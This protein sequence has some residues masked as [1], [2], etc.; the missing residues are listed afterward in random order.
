VK[1]EEKMEKE[2]E[3]PKAKKQC[4]SL[5]N[6]YK[7]KRE[8]DEDVGNYKIFKRRSASGYFQFACELLANDEKTLYE[9]YKEYQSIFTRH[10]KALERIVYEREKLKKGPVLEVTWLFGAQ[11]HE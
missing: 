10:Y 2:E 11:G 6:K 5:H 3:K 1:E 7:R 8:D 4:T 9:I